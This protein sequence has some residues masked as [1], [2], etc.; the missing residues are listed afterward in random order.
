M[1]KKIIVLTSEAKNGPKDIFSF[2]IDKI[3][4][5]KTLT[6]CTI[7]FRILANSDK[8]A[9]KYEWEIITKP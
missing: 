1:V 4:C 6:N 3:L 7:T 5:R 2:C 9:A 8:R